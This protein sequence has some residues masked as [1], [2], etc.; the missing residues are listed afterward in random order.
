M[1]TVPEIKSA[2]EKLTPQEQRQL[3]AWFEKER[4]RLDE[5]EDRC[6]L[7]DAIARNQGKP[8]TPWPDAKKQLGLE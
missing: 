8:G 3:M 2:I 6:D 1:K 5:R 7:N 4:A